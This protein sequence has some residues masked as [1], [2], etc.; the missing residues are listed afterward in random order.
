MAGDIVAIRLAVE[1]V[2]V[3]E[4]GDRVVEVVD[5]R[6]GA[7]RSTSAEE[8]AAR[9]KDEVRACDVA[10][11][12]ATFPALRLAAA[13]LKYHI[14]RVWS[15]NKIRWKIQVRKDINLHRYDRL[16]KSGRTGRFL[17]RNEVVQR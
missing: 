7:F 9:D 1:V 16:G 14:A 13:T 17:R 4:S 11:E 12:A 3:R 5:C 15:G 2:E 10:A 8:D 6:V